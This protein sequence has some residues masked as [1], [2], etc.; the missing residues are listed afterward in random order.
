M[1]YRP[2]LLAVDL[3]VVEHDPVPAVSGA[4]RRAVDAGVE[5]IVISAAGV[6]EMRRRLDAV[7][8]EAGI[9]RLESAGDQAAG[10]D[11]PRAFQALVE[12]L[13]VTPEQLAVV[14]EDPEVARTAREAGV[15]TALLHRPPK[16]FVHDPGVADV[17]G[18]A[19]ADLLDQLLDLPEPMIRPPAGY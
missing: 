13:G 4:V 6:D 19:L 2:S 9:S 14:V 7:G 18:E 16:P 15:T 3:D 5:V 10:L 11:D 8:L 17:R 1:A 12:R